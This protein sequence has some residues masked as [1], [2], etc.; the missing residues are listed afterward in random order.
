MYVIKRTDK[1]YGG[2]TIEH[3]IYEDAEAE[4]KRLA[5]KHG[6]EEPEFIVYELIEVAR[7]SAKVIIKVTD[8]SENS[9]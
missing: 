6:L 1:E 8:V 3:G 5:Q 7:I 9:G 4:A 2:Y